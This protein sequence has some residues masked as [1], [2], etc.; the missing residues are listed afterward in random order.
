[1]AFPRIMS[2]F[3]GMDGVWQ[4]EFIPTRAREVEF[5]DGNHVILPAAIFHDIDHKGPPLYICWHGTP[6][7]EGINPDRDLEEAHIKEAFHMT[8]HKLRTLMSRRLNR[9]LLRS[10]LML[11]KSII[12]G[13]VFAFSMLILLVA[14]T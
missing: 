1:M 5:I 4:S 10:A 12:L 3:G 9:L 13:F 8:Q 14:V 2:L 6:I 7:P 11:V